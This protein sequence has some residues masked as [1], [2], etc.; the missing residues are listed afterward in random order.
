MF[1]RKWK[2]SNRIWPQ[3]YSICPKLRAISRKIKKLFAV[4]LF[5]LF[6]FFCG[7]GSVFYMS[8][9]NSVGSGGLKKASVTVIMD[10]DELNKASKWRLSFEDCN[11]TRQSFHHWKCFKSVFGFNISQNL[12]FVRKCDSNVLHWEFVSDRLNKHWFYSWYGMVS[13]IVSLRK[14]WNIVS[15]HDSNVTYQILPRLFHMK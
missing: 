3:S 5:R 10:L 13:S 15:I 4:I 7:Q 9:I 11:F 14:D 6:Q 12:H 2:G 1:L 8:M